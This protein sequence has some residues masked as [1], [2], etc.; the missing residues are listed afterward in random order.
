MCL[1]ITETR[2]LNITYLPLEDL[3][4]LISASQCLARDEEERGFAVAWLLAHPTLGE[5]SVV[6]TG[7]GGFMTWQGDLDRNASF[8]L[9][10]VDR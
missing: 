6:Q 3:C 9:L 2:A 1:S 8:S 4:D 5:I 10:M 7:D